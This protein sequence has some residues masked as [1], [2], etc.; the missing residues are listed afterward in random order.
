[1][2]YY[3][4]NRYVL[5]QILTTK[6]PDFEI[7]LLV[8][9][10]VL[11]ITYRWYEVSTLSEII[12][13]P[14]IEISKERK[15]FYI[16]QRDNYLREANFIFDAKFKQHY[17]WKKPHTMA[18]GT[19]TVNTLR[20]NS[21]KWSMNHGFPDVTNVDGMDLSLSS[22]GRP[23][24]LCTL[25][26]PTTVAP[27]TPTGIKIMPT[28]LKNTLDSSVSTNKKGKESLQEKNGFTMKHSNA[29]GIHIYQS[30]KSF[31]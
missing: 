14:L 26:S 6:C 11:D 24:R 30:I 20:A 25:K 8:Y 3:F 9:D 19:A 15:L 7:H 12:P 21:L 13:L 1:M 23:L 29:R 28:N 2:I 17:D 31:R 10:E 16:K 4:S 27:A 22:T 18:I 5:L